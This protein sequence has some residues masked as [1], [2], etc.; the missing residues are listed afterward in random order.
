MKKDLSNNIQHFSGKY[1]IKFK[2]KLEGKNSEGQGGRLASAV[3]K[4]A[5]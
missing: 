3:R 1:F 2:I 5:Q 4:N